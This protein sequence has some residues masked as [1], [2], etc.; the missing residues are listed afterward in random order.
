MSISPRPFLKKISN[1]F[2]FNGILS[3]WYRHHGVLFILCFFITIFFAGWNWY[4][5]FYQYRLSDEEKK[6]YI[7]QHFRETAFKEKEFLNVVDMLMKRSHDAETLEIK[8]DIF[9]GK[10]I[11]IKP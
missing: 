6:Q 1:H 9:K 10:D 4:Y 11:Q 5:S 7:E 3:F 2:S 8:R